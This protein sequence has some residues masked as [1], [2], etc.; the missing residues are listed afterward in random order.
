[1][2]DYGGTVV[3]M[4]EASERGPSALANYGGRGMPPVEFVYLVVAEGEWPVDAVVGDA[5]AESL[6]E[7][8]VYR[9]SKPSAGWSLRQV[10]VWRAR[11]ADL[12]EMEFSPTRTIAAS[13]T[14]KRPA[15]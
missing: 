15:P 4:T 5:H 7:S 6:I 2:S 14:A 3:G 1:M 8:A 12:E 11:V 10:H 13:L 9:R